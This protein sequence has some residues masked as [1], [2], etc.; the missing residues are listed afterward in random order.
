MY[1]SL[2]QAK[3]LREGL[4]FYFIFSVLEISFVSPGFG[5]GSPVGRLQVGGRDTNSISLLAS[6]AGEKSC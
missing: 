5:V 6:N 2:N 3:S 4:R 1:L